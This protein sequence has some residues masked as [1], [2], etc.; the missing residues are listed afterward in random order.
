MNRRDAL[1]WLF[2]SVVALACVT[3][4]SMVQGMSSSPMAKTPTANPDILWQWVNGQC[5][6]AARRNIYPPSP[7]IEVSAPQG[8]A[9]GYAV[10]K[11]R[12]GRYQ[13]LVMP[14]ARVT[15]IESEALLARGAPNY[16]AD[17]W[18]ARRYVEA[19]LHTSVPRDMLSLVVNS[20]YGRSQNQLHIHI[21]CVRA[22]VHD[23]LR[24]LLPTITPHWQPL[25]EP[26]PP[27][28][29]R[30]AAMWVPGDSLTINPFQSLAASLTP[31]DRMTF[32][33]LIV[34]G[35]QSSTGEPGFIL[36]SGKVDPMTGDRGNGDDL[37][38]LACDLVTRHA[39]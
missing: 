34:V 3:T 36:L 35:A 1:R 15:G 12:D 11:D 14:L 32:H 33:S 29:H 18:D 2:G 5:A 22:D 10:F 8:S 23:T 37:Q 27:H 16:F 13:Y 4:P 17:A 7:C 9:S 24:R 39:H 28:G 6:P 30:Y 31:D 26:L 21:D 25:R 20:P 38:D 19:A